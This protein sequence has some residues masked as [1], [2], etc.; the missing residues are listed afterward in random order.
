MHPSTDQGPARVERPPAGT[1]DHGAIGNGRLI[2]LV[3]PTS[4]IEW[5]CMPRFDSP[6]VFARIL[7]RQ[8]GGSWSFQS[9][10][11]EVRGRIEYLTNTNVLRGTFE[12]CRRQPE[13]LRCGQRRSAIEPGVVQEQLA[14]L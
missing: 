12:V 3:S 10:G 1:L 8:R 11:R 14:I 13:F 6:S 9:A 2:A 5:L 7:D 4:A